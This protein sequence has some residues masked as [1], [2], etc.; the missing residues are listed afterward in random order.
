MPCALTNDGR[1]WKAAVGST[2]TLRVLADQT[3]CT[4]AMYNG[5]ALSVQ[6]NTFCFTVVPGA[7]TLLLSLVGP[8]E[9]VEI[10][11]DCGGGST[12]RLFSFANETHPV[13]QFTVLGGD[14]TRHGKGGF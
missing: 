5:T 13:L 9:A 3:E 10:V 14:E 4:G 6:N 2:V 11:E 12:Q 1:Q 8:N 7:A